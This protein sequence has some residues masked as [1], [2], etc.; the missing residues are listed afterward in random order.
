[1]YDYKDT[2]SVALYIGGI[3]DFVW[4]GAEISNLFSSWGIQNYKKH[5]HTHIY[6]Y[7]YIIL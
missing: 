6:I 1:M 3:Q 2:S 5:T 7:I 4:G